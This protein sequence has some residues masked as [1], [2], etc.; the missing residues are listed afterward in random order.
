MHLNYIGIKSGYTYCKQAWKQKTLYTEYV[1]RLLIVDFNNYYHHY[2]Q[3]TK[4]DMRK[5]TV[6]HTPARVHTHT[7]THTRKPWRPSKSNTKNKTK[8]KLTNSNGCCF[9]Q[10]KCTP[11]SIRPQT[12]NSVAWSI[13]NDNLTWTYLIIITDA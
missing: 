7:H 1:Y 4:L 12:H 10:A 13:P 9:K 8:T 6:T 11:L 2:G 5:A 3:I